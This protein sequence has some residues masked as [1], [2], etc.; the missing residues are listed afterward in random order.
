[1]RSER[2]GCFRNGEVKRRKR[3]CDKECLS[4]ARGGN[5]ADE[6]R[7]TTGRDGT[8]RSEGDEVLEGELG[9]DCVRVL[10]SAGCLRPADGDLAS[11]R[12]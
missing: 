11:D 7:E 1:M 9:G 10:Y 12:N 8:G 4:G 2:E 6:A 3:A 5:A